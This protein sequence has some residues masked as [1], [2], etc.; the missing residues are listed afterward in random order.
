M[1]L[2]GVIVQKLL[3]PILILFAIVKLFTLV[4]IL[5]L[6]IDALTSN[7]W[8]LFDHNTWLEVLFIKLNDD[9]IHTVGNSVLVGVSIDRWR[10]L[11]LLGV[12]VYEV[13]NV[14]LWLGI[15]VLL[16]GLYFWLCDKVTFAKVLLQP[17]VLFLFIFLGATLLLW[18]IKVF[19]LFRYE[20][21]HFFSFV[22]LN[23]FYW[24]H[25]FIFF[26]ID[27]VLRISHFVVL[28]FMISFWLR[29]FVLILLFML[30]KSLIKLVDSNGVFIDLFLFTIHNFLL[31]LIGGL[32]VMIPC[33]LFFWQE[34][35]ALFYCLF[36]VFIVEQELVLSFSMILKILFRWISFNFCLFL[37]IH[38]CYWLYFLNKSNR[39][40]YWSSFL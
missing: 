15:F 37:L 1:D 29:I 26:E 16:R 36:I 22:S 10:N 2:T 6:L 34:R 4:Q 17:R 31:V 14:G 27:E 9:F 3:P 32:Y 40:W 5:S 8:L 35:L 23:P 30:I 38:V 24:S 20:F 19:I 21:F 18:L 13:V 25:L 11:T 39:V 7:I 28:L 33:D 12:V